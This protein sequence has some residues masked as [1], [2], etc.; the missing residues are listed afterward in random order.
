MEAAQEK[1]SAAFERGARERWRGTMC[2]EARKSVVLEH[3]LRLGVS[4]RWRIV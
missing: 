2:F 3:D 4:Q 1:M